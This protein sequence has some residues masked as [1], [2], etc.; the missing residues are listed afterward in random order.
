MGREKVSDS[1]AKH[2]RKAPDPGTDR[3]ER[4]RANVTVGRRKAKARRIKAG[5]LTIAETARKYGVSKAFVGRK[6][7]RREVRTI[8]SGSRRFIHVDEA[9]RVFGSH[10]QEGTAA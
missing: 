7:D 8:E 2:S 9:E 5:L 6:A 1:I 4:W 3:Y 10:T